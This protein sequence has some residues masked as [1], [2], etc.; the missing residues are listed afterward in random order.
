MVR[1]VAAKLH[2]LHGQGYVAYSRNGYDSGIQPAPR[3]ASDLD[4]GLFV[5]LTGRGG[6]L[7]ES[8]FQPDCSKAYIDCY[9]MLD[10]GT[11]VVTI[12][13]GSR[14]MLTDMMPAALSDGNLLSVSNMTS[15]RPWYATYWK[16]IR[17][18]YMV[19]MT[20]RGSSPGRLSGHLQSIDWKLKL[21]G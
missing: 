6:E 19:E 13:C 4:R 17:V 16:P 15:F 18:G 11:E 8:I 21:D 20:F 9:D 5:M 10:E 12:Q 2:E 7:W 1:E 14:S 3:N